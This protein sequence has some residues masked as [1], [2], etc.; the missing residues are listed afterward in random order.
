MLTRIQTAVSLLYPPRCLGCGTMVDSDFGLCGG[1]WRDT[2]FI[3]GTVCDSC[4]SPVPGG[5]DGYRVEC[6]DCMKTPR[7]WTDGRA[8]LLYKDRARRM[9]LALKH[10]D[11][12]EIARPAALWMM[13]A[14]RPILR[15]NM[16]IAPVPLHWTRFLKRRYNQSALLA[17]EV[18]RQ[19][20]LPNCPDLL[21][22]TK[23]TAMLDGKTAQERFSDL[24]DAIRVHPKR[25]HRLVARSILLVDDVMTTGATLT[26][27]T[28]ACLDAGAH[29]VC[30]LTLARVAKDA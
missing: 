1:C 21:L 12:P 29:D 14:A 10:G 24:S 28:R 5:A 22:R 25:R 20:G 30:V 19:T 8:A 23:R 18:A 9:V 26:A 7:L 16:L 11:R 15:E 27:C 6:D 4:G 3:G 17:Q 2:P 13:R